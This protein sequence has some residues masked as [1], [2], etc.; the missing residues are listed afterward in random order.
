MVMVIF[1]VRILLFI[2]NVNFVNI[3]QVIIIAWKY[4]EEMQICKYANTYRCK[5]CKYSALDK[6]LM[7]KHMTVIV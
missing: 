3:M 2:T 7:E 5:R 1:I 6:E 4:M